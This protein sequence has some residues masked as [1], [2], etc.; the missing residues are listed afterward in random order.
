MNS[1]GLRH[2]AAPN[3]ASG[4]RE[5]LGRPVL[6]SIQHLRALAASL[7]LLFH[8]KLL[9][10][11]FAGV[12]VFF[13]ISGF[14]M[15]TIGVKE[16][17][18]AFIGNRLVRIV[19][20]Y[21]LV[22]LITCGLSLVPGAMRNFH[23]DAGQLFRSLLFVPYRNA[24]GDIL[25]LIVPGWT[26]NFEMFFYALFAVL[27]NT[28]HV[29]GWSVAVLVFLG[30][31]GTLWQFQNPVLATY[32]SPLLLEF[33]AGLILSMMAPVKGRNAARAVFL[34]GIAGFVA[35]MSL[36]DPA[37]DGLARAFLLGIPATLIVAG[38]LACER[39]GAWPRFGFAKQLG[40][41]SY[42]LYLT[43]GLVLAGVAKVAQRIGAGVGAS[44]A[45][46]LAASVAVA[47]VIFH[48][49]EKPIMRWFRSVRPAA[50]T[51]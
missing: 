7:V 32:C 17:P 45:L 40:D 28:R 49:F 2:V 50:K 5:Q 16:R 44:D 27:L 15:G 42:S 34:T 46:G 26:L 10:M 9:P 47:V 51:G 38:A 13:V 37:I 35:M 21:W 11:G 25:P 14:I 8:L 43:H 29:R 33:A 20:L 1:I 31:A 39:A 23:F 36:G 30:L 18:K 3:L 48:G 19:P 22:T 6:S 24:D 4:P 12:D 41:A